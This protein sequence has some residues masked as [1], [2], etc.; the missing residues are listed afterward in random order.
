MFDIVI[1]MLVWFKK[2]FELLFYIY[3][4]IYCGVVIEGLM[5]ND[6]FIVVKMWMLSGLFWIQFV[7]EDYI[8]VVDGEINMIY[9]EI[10]F[11]FYLVQLLDDWFDN[12]E[13]FLNLYKSNIVW[14]D[15]S[16]LYDID[17]DGVIFI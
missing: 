10:D 14:L 9:L 16:E 15:F 4:I 3:N 12:G 5:Y 1:G 13:W 6:D 7:G 8:I 2:G 11:G 17:V